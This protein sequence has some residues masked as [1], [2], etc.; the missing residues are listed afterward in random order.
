MAF[1]ALLG[2]KSLMED[3]PSSCS[4]STPSEA[5]AA[6][7][8]KGSSKR[9][10]SAPPLQ[11][12]LPTRMPCRTRGLASPASSA[13]SSCPGTPDFSSADSPKVKKISQRKLATLEEK[14]RM[15]REA[16]NSSF[17]SWWTNSDSSQDP[18]GPPPEKPK[19]PKKLKEK[20]SLDWNDFCCL[21][22]TGNYRRFEP[23]LED[24]PEASFDKDVAI[25]ELHSVLRHHKLDPTE[26]LV[27]DMLQWQAR[28]SERNLGTLGSPVAERTLPLSSV[29]SPE[30]NGPCP[31]DSPLIAATSTSSEGIDSLDAARKISLDSGVDA[32]I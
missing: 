21:R 14:A 6:D 31:A 28:S 15:D 22:D 3:A 18:L 30:L 11:P 17:F 12:C 2:T 13:S 1:M 5:A 8:E 10:Q 19:K 20:S 23:I 26:A 32:E 25:L 29:D 27:K 9:A 16:S 24:Q 7:G 4:T